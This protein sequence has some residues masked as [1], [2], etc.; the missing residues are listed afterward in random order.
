MNNQNT[1]SD[2]VLKKARK[3]LENIMNDKN[4]FINDKKRIK[5]LP[6]K[7]GLKYYPPYIKWLLKKLFHEN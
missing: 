6:L 1:Y 3:H 7:L 5:W 4:S 2:E